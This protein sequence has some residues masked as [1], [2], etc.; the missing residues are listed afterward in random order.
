MNPN[1]APDFARDG[2]VVLAGLLTPEQV[3]EAVDHLDRS[4][5]RLRLPDDAPVVAV[6]P[7]EATDLTRSGPVPAAASLLLEG[8]VELFGLSYLCKPAGCGL[9]ALWHQDGFPW[10]ERLRG[11]AAITIWVALDD[12]DSNNGCLRMVPGSHA[13]P[14]QPLQKIRSPPSMFGVQIDPGLVDDTRAV[15]LPLSAGDGSAHHPS[16]VHSSRA[17]RSTRPRRAVA[18]R[19]RSLVTTDA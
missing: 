19:Y 8:P 1:L 11:A 13:L 4:R 14:A 9:P 18:I 17:N 3:E 15:D 16:L 5:R 7:S 2:F 6:P 12:T 10:Q